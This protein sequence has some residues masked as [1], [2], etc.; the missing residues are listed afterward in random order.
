MAK[1]KQDEEVLVDV[2]EVYSKS[3]EFIE[4]NRNN[5]L[6]VIGILV[7]IVVG[8]I[9][10]KKFYIEPQEEDAT[11]DMFQAESYFEKDS[12]Q[13]AIEGDGINF[14]FLDIIDEYPQTQCA[15]LATYYTGISYLHLK[16]YDLAIEYL[17]AYD[18]TDEVVGP[19]AL[20]AKGDAHMELGQYDK[21][22]E[23][24]LEAAEQSDNSL[25]S[26]I[27]LMKA[28]FCSE[29]IGEYEAAIG[30]YKR[31]KKEY[32]NSEEARNAAKYIARANARMGK[33]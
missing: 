7:I 21:A 15:N 8:F 19:I 26:P 10:Y 30:Y 13:L 32:H 2:G 22:L 29:F 23:H 12:F 27:Y 16:D 24:Y 14:G 18:A 17:D 20:G 5:I 11:V 6:T 3:E 31:I 4:N 25:I 9:S 33:S 1:K 28:G